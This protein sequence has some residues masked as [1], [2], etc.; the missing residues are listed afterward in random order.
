MS[1]MSQMK[2]IENNIFIVDWKDDETLVEGE[3][4]NTYGGDFT[5]RDVVVKMTDD[6]LFT[7]WE[8]QYGQCDV[9]DEFMIDD[10]REI[11]EFV[12]EL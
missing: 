11:K 9:Y 4:G 6:N 8:N 7:L 5:Y 12:L 1:Q 10:N 2:H 3:V